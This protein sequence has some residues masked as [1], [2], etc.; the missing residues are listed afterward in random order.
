MA[1]ASLPVP[2]RPIAFAQCIVLADELALLGAAEV[3]L[4]SELVHAR[5]RIH[6]DQPIAWAP[7]AWRWS[8]DG[9]LRLDCGSQRNS[10]GKQAPCDHPH[11]ACGQFHGSTADTTN[12]LQHLSWSDNHAG[13][14]VGHQSATCRGCCVGRQVAESRPV[15][16]PAAKRCGRQKLDLRSAE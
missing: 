11:L 4:A 16:N 13:L 9:R 8:V 7:H 2:R 15:E 12:R 6:P 3:P 1:A 10:H 5:P 14:L